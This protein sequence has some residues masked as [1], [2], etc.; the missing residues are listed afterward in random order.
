M[1]INNEIIVKELDN[2]EFPLFTDNK[3]VVNDPNKMVI[4]TAYENHFTK[5]TPFDLSGQ[6]QILLI[7]WTIVQNR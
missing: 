7:S 5:K 6:Y 3:C 4:N 1:L 2:I